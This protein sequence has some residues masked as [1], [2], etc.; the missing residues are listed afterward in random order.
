[1]NKKQ[2]KGILMTA[3]FV[4]AVLLILLDQFTKRLAIVKL[5][6]QEAFPIL[7]D[8]FELDYLENRGSAFGMFQNKKVFL[9]IMGFVFMALVIWVIFRTPAQKRFLPVH[10]VAVCLLAGGIGNM[11]DRFL[12]GYVVDFFSFVLI[13]FPVFN[14]ADIY[15]TVSCAALLILHV[16][17]YKEDELSFLF[18]SGKKEESKEV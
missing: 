18:P 15:I 7:K 10:I 1:M 14:V 2:S 17:V 16:F 11:L 5:K 9:L 3:D 12:L 8:I 13:H 4:F 6:G